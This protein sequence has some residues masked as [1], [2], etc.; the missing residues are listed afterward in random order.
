MGLAVVK[1]G[2]VSRGI[3]TPDMF[4]IVYPENDW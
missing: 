4:D 2:E 1:M 3:A